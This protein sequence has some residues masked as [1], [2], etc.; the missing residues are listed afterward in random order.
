MYV[1]SCLLG[2]VVVACVYVCDYVVFVYYMH[3]VASVRACVFASRG[4]H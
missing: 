2:C 4:G 1:C 3:V